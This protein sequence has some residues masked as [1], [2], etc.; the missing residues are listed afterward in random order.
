MPASGDS[1]SY[2]L[3]PAV[4]FFFFPGAVSVC[5]FAHPLV[6]L[7]LD[8]LTMSDFLCS[9]NGEKDHALGTTAEKTEACLVVEGVMHVLGVVSTQLYL[10]YSKV[11]KG[12]R[13]QE[14]AAG[15]EAN[16]FGRRKPG[17]IS[18]G[19]RRKIQKLTNFNHSSP[20][21]KKILKIFI[22]SSPDLV[23]P[24]ENEIF[25]QQKYREQ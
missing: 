18:T 9:S 5:C 22:L 16:S 17:G 19:T 12:V 8:V 6:G 20:T 14:I 25:F 21:K 13:R 24:Q 1:L 7:L 4:I 10:Y 15:L 23:T 2:S 11:I 3:S